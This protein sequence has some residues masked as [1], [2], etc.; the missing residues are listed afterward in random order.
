MMKINGD[1]N[2]LAVETAAASGV[3]R[4]VYISSIPSTLPSSVLQG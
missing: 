1:A 3:D 4:F 2:A